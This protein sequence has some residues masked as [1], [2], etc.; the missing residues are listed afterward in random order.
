MPREFKQAALEKVLHDLCQG[1][2]FRM[3]AVAAANGLL[4]SSAGPEAELMAAVAANLFTMV[5]RL[6]HLD[7][8]DEIVIRSY[9]GRQFVCRY[10]TSRG[11]AL[12][13]IGLLKT[14]QSYRRRTNVAIHRLQ[15]VWEM[16]LA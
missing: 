3:A 13:L 7:P 2:Y 9:N 16:S 14:G 6:S 5:Q 8:L 12:I 15:A 11:D 4:V 10:F 1:G